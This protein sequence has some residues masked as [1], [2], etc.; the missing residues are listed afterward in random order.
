MFKK[1]FEIGTSKYDCDGDVF[2]LITLTQNALWTCPYLLFELLGG[3]FI[4]IQIL[5]K[6][7]ISKQ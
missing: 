3:I 2:S 1:L 7:S 5:A 6:H 4:F